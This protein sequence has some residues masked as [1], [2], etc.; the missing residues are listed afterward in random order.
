MGL[1]TFWAG[2]AAANWIA[3]V[4][5]MSLPGA[6]NID[7]VTASCAVSNMNYPRHIT[8]TRVTR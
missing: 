7:F 5:I 1:L 8:W 6:A 4:A 3:K 2:L